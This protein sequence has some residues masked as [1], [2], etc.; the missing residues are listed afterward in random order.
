M[1]VAAY[2]RV[3]TDK[4]D[5]ANSFESQKRFF[6]Q[7]IQNQPGWELYQ[8]YADEG[9]T[10]TSTK[11]RAAFH[12]M[13]Q[14]AQ[15]HRFQRILTKEVSRFSRNILDTISYTRDL[16]RL[17][18]GVQFVND[19]IDTLDP[20]AELRLSIM[21]SIAQ[22][23]SRRTSSRVKWGQTRRMEQGV[24]F[25]RSL[26]GYD[27]HDG[28]MTVNPEGAKLVR[29]IFHKCVQER[30]GTTVIAR[31]LR[32]A[33]FRTL[34]GSLNWRGAVILKILKNE[35]YCGDLK[36][37]K[38]I[39]P[40]YL[41]HQKKYNHGEEDFVF[42][43]DHHQ[44]IV[45]REMWEAAQRE[46]ARRDSDGGRSTGH[47][48]RYPLSGKV[49]CGV[50]GGNFVSRR[51]THKDGSLCQ[52]WRCGTAAVQ[53]RPHTESAGNVTGCDLGYSLGNRA[54]LDLVRRSVAAL[55][56]DREEIIRC[57]TCIAL[58]SIRAAREDTRAQSARLQKELNQ[59]VEKKKAALDAFLSKSISQGDLDLMKAQYD[60]SI[61][62]LTE[63]L[64][65]A[66]TGKCMSQGSASLEVELRDK[67]AEIV[68]GSAG[69]DSFYGN[70]L[71]CITAFPHRRLEVRLKGLPFQWTYELGLA[72]QLREI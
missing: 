63:A 34:T 54:G 62:Q 29:L 41:T 5:Q 14:D 72:G 51:R 40:D 36:Q 25:G 22:E 60:S 17:G 47:G 61:A 15:L 46:I 59:L 67:V 1:L 3:S 10:G 71:E 11:K 50:C 70:L 32:E 12:H 28:K 35:K 9:I 68:T 37:K 26:L 2:C 38:T 8:I 48:N 23:E 39:T 53:G 31:E 66:E 20:D 49:K 18:I 7:Y 4:E 55:N 43:K 21:G 24:V 30:K 44:P 58:E 57:V 27:V 33:G 56:L 65:A 42:L 45:S 64:T 69:P 13:I 6:Y 19:G 16:R 52:V